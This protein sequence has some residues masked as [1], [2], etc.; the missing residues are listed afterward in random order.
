VNALAPLVREDEIVLDA[1]AANRE[2]LFALASRL[3]AAHHGLSPESIRSALEAREALGSTAMGHGI[4]IPH[5]R[6][7]QLS[8]PALAYI[9]LRTPIEFGAHDRKPVSQFLVLLVPSEANE[10]HLKLMAAA[11]GALSDKLVRNQLR[12]CGGCGEAKDA[13]SQWAAEAAQGPG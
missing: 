3:L 4:A 10:K 9:R 8:E 11:A 12:T 1:E 5:A 2:E 6:M 13:L 7:P